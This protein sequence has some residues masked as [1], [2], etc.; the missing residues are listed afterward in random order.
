MPRQTTTPLPQLIY[1]RIIHLRRRLKDLI[2]KPIT[3]TNNNEEKVRVEIS[4]GP[5][6]RSF[7]SWDAA[8]TEEYEPINV[9]DKFSPAYVTN[10]DGIKEFPWTQRWFRVVIHDLDTT[11]LQKKEDKQE[12]QL[13]DELCLYFLANGEF[14]VYTSTGDVWCGIDPVHDR[15]PLTSLLPQD[16][17][18][19]KTSSTI[20]IWLDGGQWQT[21]FWFGLEPPTDELGFRLIKV[22]L[23]YKNTLA[24]EVYHDLS[25]LIEWIECMYEKEGIPT[26]TENGYYHPLTT[27]PP[28]LRRALHLLNKV[29]DLYDRTK[30]LTSLRQEINSIYKVMTTS[31]DDGGHNMKICH[32]GH[33]H[34]KFIHEISL[35]RYFYICVNH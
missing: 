22:Q 30:C 28:S 35:Q 9:G 34:S 23:E 3:T 18:G 2:T 13:D 21:G 12:G 19:T 6:H 32:V 11:L 7:I 5:T 15:I 33:A 10:A 31:S 16:A 8:I 17:D 27:V 14:T 25:M 29:C 26:N 24:N 1:P 20:T 4:I